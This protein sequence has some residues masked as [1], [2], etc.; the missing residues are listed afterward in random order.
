MTYHFHPGALGGRL[1]P[2]PALVLTALLAACG[3]DNEAP[4][5]T[6]D[7]S[8]TVDAGPIIP[9]DCADGSRTLYRVTALHIPTP[10]EADG[11][12]VVGHNVDGAGDVCGVPDYAGGVDNSLVDLAAAL[13]SLSP[14]D[15]IDLQ[16]E[17]DTALGCAPAATDCTRL[18]LIVS[19]AT[20]TNCVVVEVLDG[21]GPDATTLAGPFLGS[22]NSSGQVRGVVPSLMLA[23]PYQTDTGSVDINL[24]VTNVVLT[25]TIGDSS[26]TNIVLGGSLERTAF[27][28]TIRDLLPLLGGEIAIDDILPILANLY[29]VQVNGSC[30]ALS[31]GLTGLASLE[32]TP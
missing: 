25:A 12:A 29:D 21:V 2:V 31:V 14:E 4:V 17:I 28:Q 20:G 10:T 3:P 30:A 23:I 5:G 7:A 19:V 24:A 13:P 32:A 22:L 6:R 27:E 8:V 16:A 15:P 9:R 26:L 1:V 11:G 18:D